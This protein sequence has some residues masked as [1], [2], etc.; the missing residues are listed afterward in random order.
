MRNFFRMQQAE[1]CPVCKADWPGDHFVG[2]RAL[3][4]RSRP[5]G[6]APRQT[7]GASIELS[8]QSSPSRL[9]PDG[10]IDENPDENSE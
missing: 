6:V 4:S 9:A 2:E 3:S 8:T 5:S 10:N 7:R 1:Q